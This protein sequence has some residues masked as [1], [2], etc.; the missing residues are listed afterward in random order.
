MPS[1]CKKLWGTKEILKCSCGLLDM[2]KLIQIYTVMIRVPVLDNIGDFPKYAF[3]L[4]VSV[5]MVSVALQGKLLLLTRV[6]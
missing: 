5:C 4:R 6:D 1:C 2:L 3:L